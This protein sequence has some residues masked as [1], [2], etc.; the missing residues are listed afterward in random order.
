MNTIKN[1]TFQ[2]NH[3]ET[4]YTKFK[5][6]NYKYYTALKSNIDNHLANI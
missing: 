4:N 6:V 3:M 1:G 5:T 2:D